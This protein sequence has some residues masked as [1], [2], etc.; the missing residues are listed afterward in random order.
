[1]LIETYVRVSPVYG[2][3]YGIGAD[4][5]IKDF[6]KLKQQLNE[7]S[8]A[9]NKFESEAV[10]LRVVELVL[11]QNDPRPGGFSEG[12]INDFIAGP[13]MMQVVRSTSRPG[14]R[15]TTTDSAKGAVAALNDLLESD[16][17]DAPR[18]IGDIVARC[19]ETFG[20]RYKSNAF[21]GPLSRHARTGVLSREKN[22]D[23][24]FV[25]VKPGTD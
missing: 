12:G 8:E 22:A 4:F 15:R 3:N 24:K 11:G 1:M 6:D 5:M 17:F 14:R 7:L 13:G 10:Q 2:G 20:M 23:G 19:Q 21:S 9:V 25:Y 18:T 16:F